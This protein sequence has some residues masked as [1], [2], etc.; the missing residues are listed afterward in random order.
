M[1]RRR[2]G[3]HL[4]HVPPRGACLRRLLFICTAFPPVIGGGS[5]RNALIARGLA[6]RDWDVTVLTGQRRSP[7]WDDASPLR[8][9]PSAVRVVRAFAPDPTAAGRRRAVG[10]TAPRVRGGVIAATRGAMRRF[11]LTW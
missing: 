9:M 6:E 4:R 8:I 5:V 11:V 2:V 7:V 1:A 3:R 10:A